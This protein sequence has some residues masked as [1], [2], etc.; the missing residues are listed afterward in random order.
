MNQSVP[1]FNKGDNRK[2]NMKLM[3]IG[4][5]RK[6]K[7]QWKKNGS[8]PQNDYYSYDIYHMS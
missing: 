8:Q 3:K 2:D 5:K 6:E 1:V 4:I 7:I